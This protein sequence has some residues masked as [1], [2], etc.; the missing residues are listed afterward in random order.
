MAA[1]RPAALLASQPMVWL[2]MVMALAN[3]LGGYVMVALALNTNE[4]VVVFEFFTHELSQS[5]FSLSLASTV[6]C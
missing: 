1:I 4:S 2:V 6:R 3:S 5:D